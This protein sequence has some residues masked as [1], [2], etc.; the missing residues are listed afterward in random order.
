MIEA[1]RNLVE[2]KNLNKTFNDATGE[3]QVLIDFSLSIEENE[4][5]CILG[6][7]GC[8]K[9][10]LLRCMCGLE[11]YDGD[12]LI[13]GQKI[14]SANTGSILVF[15]DF[16]QLFPWKTVEQNILFAMKQSGKRDKTE[17]K[18]LVEEYLLKVGLL[19]CRNYYPHQL[20]GGMKQRIA[21]VRALAMKPKIILMDEPFASLDAITRKKLQKELLSIVE[22]ENLTVV[23]I[24][25]NIQEAITLGSKIMVMADGG[26]IKCNVKNNIK[27]PVTPLSNGYGEMWEMFNAALEEN[28]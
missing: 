6:P 8:G 19:E 12:I 7:S 16:N 20:S 4:F 3:K 1:Q 28:N 11:E 24:T 21:I 17:M 15:Q 10:T 18:K 25:H 5:F 23:F 27:K 2:I 13:D 14:V 9:T 26:A 22:K